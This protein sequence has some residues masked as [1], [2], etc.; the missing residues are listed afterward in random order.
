VS[1]PS[2]INNLPVTSIATIAFSG[3]ESLAS[4][5]IPDSVISIG[6]GAFF[7]CS[8]LTNIRIGKSVA[9][10]GKDMFFRCASLASVTIPDSVTSIGSNAFGFCSSLA[11]VSIGDGVSSIGSTAFSMCW[12]L[13]NLAIPSSVTNIGAQAFL[14]SSSLR[15]VYFNGNAPSPSTDTSV[16]IADNNATV[17]YLPGT[18]GWGSTFGG[19]PTVLWNL[20]IEPASYGVRTHQFR[21]NIAGSSNLVI[22]IEATTNL[23]NP[24]WHPLQTNTLSRNPL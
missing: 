15:G 8:S 11:S 17:Y 19:R 23:A 13:T 24:T 20:Q 4:V 22:V 12:S 2:E 3:D 5:T 18:K 21:F 7:G 10:I 1:L 6:G 9:S 16:F 14:G